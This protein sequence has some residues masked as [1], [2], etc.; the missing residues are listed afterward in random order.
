MQEEIIV[1][2]VNEIEP[3]YCENVA[4]VVRNN[5][6]MNL[7]EF[8]TKVNDFVELK[9][10]I[11]L[12]NLT[13]AEIKSTKKELS[14]L[15]SGI[16]RYRID[17]TKSYFERFESEMKELVANID[18]VSQTFTDSINAAKD[19]VIKVR[20]MNVK[21]LIN[22]TLEQF[23]MSTALGMSSTKEV[24]DT[25]NIY[26][27]L[28]EG[29]L[30][31]KAFWVAG[32]ESDIKP[33]EVEK[34]QDNVKKLMDEFEIIKNYQEDVV[35]ILKDY[36]ANFDLTSAIT[37]EKARRQKIEDDRLEQERIA[38]VNAQMKAQ[39]EK[40]KLESNGA[41]KEDT[42]KPTKITPVIK[43]SKITVDYE[44]EESKAHK[45]NTLI[46]DLIKSHGAEDV[47]ITVLGES[48][49]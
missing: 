26:K 17:Y 31:N 15:S 3:V 48:D 12:E 4:L 7:E 37:N 36:Y 32:G 19:K 42:I 1:E 34:F 22:S 6:I 27:L 44:I 2:Y 20:K 9:S 33:K 29:I 46:L 43:Y 39:I 49:E 25:V 8:K 35:D 47:K 24:L 16:S 28:P 41:I 18:A 45:L 5:A 14:R 21:M 30:T 11:G 40:S 10:E 23:N 13:E 38:Q